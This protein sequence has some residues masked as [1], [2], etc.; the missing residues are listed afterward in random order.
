MGLTMK[1]RGSRESP[2]VGALSERSMRSIFYNDYTSAII[3]IVIC[4]L[5]YYFSTWIEKVPIALAQG[6]QPASFPQ[7]VLVAIL[8][9]VLLMLYESREIP[10]D[11]PDPV[12]GL[13]YKTIGAMFIALAISTWF[14]FFIGLIAF[15]VVSVQIWGLRRP[16]VA[17]AYAIALNG[18]LILLFSTLLQVRFPKGP[19]TNLLG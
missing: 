4:A 18:V 9:L 6:I 11:V 7:G 17:V 16:Y 1:E 3:I 10:L 5:V 2:E 19:F 15:V 13:G 14:D 12:S 8:A